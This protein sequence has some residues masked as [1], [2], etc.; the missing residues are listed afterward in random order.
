[1]L[2]VNCKV[3]LELKW[4]K[5]FLFSV[6]GAAADNSSD[7]P[8]NIFIIK[9]TKLH[10]SVVILSSKNNQKQSNRFRKRF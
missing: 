8:N 10:F 7:N 2:L 6:P 1:M 4:R 5:H 3:E 9:D